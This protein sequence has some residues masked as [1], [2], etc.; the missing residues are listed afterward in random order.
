MNRSEFI[1]Y[2]KHPE[3]LSEANINSLNGL[4]NDF[5]YFQTAHL[6][7]A[8]NLY[9][10]NSIY[11]NSQ[12]KIAAAYSGNR[13]ILYDL[14][15]SKNKPIIVEEKAEKT[16]AQID[17]PKESLATFEEKPEKLEEVIAEVK[18]T[19]VSEPK[20]EKEIMSE[21]IS[22]YIG[23]EVEKEI[24]N[25]E[26]ENTL[27][28][29]KEVVEIA[30]QETIDLNKKYSFQDWLKI[31]TGKVSEHEKKAIADDKS[32]QD[33][34]DKFID[35]EP[36]ISKPKAEFFSPVNLARKGVV[37]DDNFVSETLAKIYEAQ[38]HYLK[39]IRAYDSLILKYP[40][41]KLSFA[42]RIKELKKKLIS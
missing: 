11:Y 18:I 5:P 2:L 15:H 17:S 14:I 12:L 8:K 16:V 36:R 32:T 41:K 4:V 27:L 6:L 10:Q 20:L 23:M 35:E 38:G 33:L 26:K 21:I 13:K 3:K 7:Y 29:P 31:K 34:I 9:N 28:S 42:T 37:D 22:S 1:S 24:E 39:A 30:E 25:L 19:S 40:E